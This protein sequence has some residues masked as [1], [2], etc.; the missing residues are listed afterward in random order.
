MNL[1]RETLR[2]WNELKNI[3]CETQLLHVVENNTN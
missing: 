3:F 1:F 2:L